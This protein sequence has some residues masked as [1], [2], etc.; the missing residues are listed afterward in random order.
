MNVKWIG[1]P[2]AVFGS[3]ALDC[4]WRNCDVTL[5]IPR[6][7]QRL[8]VIDRRDTTATKRLDVQR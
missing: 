3:V 4:L 1:Q 8:T 2:M 7:R 6:D 5:T